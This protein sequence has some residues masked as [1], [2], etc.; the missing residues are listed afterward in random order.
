MIKI[1]VADDHAIIREGVKNIL[2]GTADM[3]VAGEAATRHETIDKI[4]KNNYDVALLDV[5][6]PDNGLEVLKQIKTGK[7]GLN[8]LVLSIHPEEHY[9][10]RVFRAG[11]DGYITKACTQT[12][13]INALRKVSLG[14]KYVSPAFAEKLAADLRSNVSQP[15]HVT[16][17]NREYQVLNMIATGKTI[18]VIAEEMTLSVKTISTYRSRIL[19]KMKLKNSAE[20]IHYAIKHGL[21][22]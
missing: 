20:I 8:V 3:V 7:P 16:L 9:A 4:W 1:L 13:L 2:S 15:P 21:A 17:S 11:A 6:S 5:S 22:N 12:E 10:T 14:R 18:K 19:L